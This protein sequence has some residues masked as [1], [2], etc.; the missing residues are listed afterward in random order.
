MGALEEEVKKTIA[1]FAV[2]VLASCSSRKEPV[3]HVPEDT[4]DC[5]AACRHLRG[6]D[7]S[8][9]SCDEGKDLPDGTTCEKFCEDV[10][11]AGHRLDPS[12]V[13]RIKECAD[14][15]RLQSFCPG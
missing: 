10:Q 5:P 8:G 2:L 1:A 12:C 15:D 13:V 9:L 11:T 14:M 6:E 7:G 4:P 3:V